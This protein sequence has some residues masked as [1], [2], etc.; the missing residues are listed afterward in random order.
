MT[1]WKPDNSSGATQ[2]SGDARQEPCWP[3]QGGDIETPWWNWPAEEDGAAEVLWDRLNSTE[4]KQ[5]AL[6][7]E[8]PTRLVLRSPTEIARLE[9]EGRLVD[10]LQ[11]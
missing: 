7:D 4:E 11:A 9:S 8:W 2:Q 10:A 1:R 6:N 5:L 3:D